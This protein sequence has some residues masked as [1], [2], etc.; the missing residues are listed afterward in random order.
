MGVYKLSAQC[1]RI[2]IIIKH[3]KLLYPSNTNGIVTFVEWDSVEGALLIFYY[4]IPQFT[5][6]RITNGQWN[7]ESC[8]IH[9]EKRTT[10]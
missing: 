10:E 5:G 8:V 1:D 7:V 2:H 6:L 9:M 3:S 4:T